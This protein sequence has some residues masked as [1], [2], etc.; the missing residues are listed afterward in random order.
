MNDNTSQCHCCGG[1]FH[2]D[3]MA[4]WTICFSCMKQ[5]MEEIKGEP[6][7]MDSLGIAWTQSELDEAGGK[8]EVMKMSKEAK[9]PGFESLPPSDNEKASDE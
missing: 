1:Y 7:F 6:V 4:D 2:S 3:M 9:Y 8:E 5:Q